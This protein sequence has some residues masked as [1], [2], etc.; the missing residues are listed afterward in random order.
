MKSPKNPNKNPKI[1][2]KISAE[3][4]RKPAYPNYLHKR[5]QEKNTPYHKIDHAAI[6]DAAAR[7]CRRRDLD[8]STTATTA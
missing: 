7:V 6:H 1:P 4:H 5:N 3:Q 2:T 8:R